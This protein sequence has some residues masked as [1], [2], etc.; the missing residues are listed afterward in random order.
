[1]AERKWKRRA[2][3]TAER[4]RFLSL[5]ADGYTRTAAR[6]EMA[7]HSE[8]YKRTCEEVPEFR[9]AVN[10]ASDLPLSEL[11]AKQM[12]KARAG[13]D[14][15]QRFLIGHFQ[16]AK[17]D[18]RRLDLARLEYKLKEAIA[19]GELKSGGIDLLKLLSD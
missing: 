4:E 15:A 2:M 10:D 8:T 17:T 19:K 14:D 13:D 6:R 3:Y 7:V 9:Q 1:M 18:G 11:V 12:A 16:R 5:L